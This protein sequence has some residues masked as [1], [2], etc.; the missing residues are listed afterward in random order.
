[1]RVSMQCSRRA[2]A[3]HNDRSYRSSDM[4]ENE[5]DGVFVYS[6]NGDK[7]IQ[8]AELEYYRQA[9][10]KAL[11]LQ[12]EKHRKRRQYA[13]IK[14]VE[15]VY[16]CDRYQPEEM[17]LQIGDMQQHT[18]N[19]DFQFCVNEYCKRMNSWNQKHGS[20]FK[21]LSIA[22]HLDE[23][24]PHAHLRRVWQYE[25]A[26]MLKIG[27]EKA[28]EQAGVP[29]PEPSKKAGRYNNRKMTFDAYQRK[30]WQQVC[31]TVLKKKY[32]IS[33]ETEPRKYD[34][35]HLTVKEYKDYAARQA[36]DKQQRKQHSR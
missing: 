17:I 6:W 22:I 35:P 20:P 26:G 11:D 31:S 10:T 9:F 25:D 36:A 23:H 28:L 8:V 32:G 1:M 7:N 12:N 34:R 2:A 14:T 30:V 19:Y 5:K 29:L 27:Q 18:S 21:F 24:T 16:E 15:Q 33:I 4:H 13:R 3:R